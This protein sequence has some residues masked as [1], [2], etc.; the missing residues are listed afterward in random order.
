MVTKLKRPIH[1]KLNR[2]F[3]TF[4]I[5]CTKSQQCILLKLVQ[6]YD[7]FEQH[8]SVEGFFR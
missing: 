3:L 5:N 7:F 8:F 6:L 2:H 1:L 4:L